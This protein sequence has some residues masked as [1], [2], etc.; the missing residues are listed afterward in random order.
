M[1]KLRT[2]I[3]LAALMA[4]APAMACENPPFAGGVD[5]HQRGWYYAYDSSQPGGFRVPGGTILPGAAQ[6]P[7]CGG[8][9]GQYPCP[10]P[11]YVPD[12]R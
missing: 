3:A 7:G 10:P 2:S 12:R 8:G 11:V 5:S 4:A 6:S 9:A 1:T